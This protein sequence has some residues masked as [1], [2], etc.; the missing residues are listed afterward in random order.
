MRETASLYSHAR[1]ALP[2]FRCC[3]VLRI[4]PKRLGNRRNAP[5]ANTTSNAQ[6]RMMAARPFSAQSF[7][8]GVSGLESLYTQASEFD[9]T[10]RKD[11]RVC[12]PLAWRVQSHPDA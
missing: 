11:L 4:V 6:L 8:S 9:V 2:R 5:A 3:V 7:H 1:S 10:L 12:W